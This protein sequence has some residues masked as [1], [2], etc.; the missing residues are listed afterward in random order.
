MSR[1]GA[2]ER[3]E[4]WSNKLLVSPRSDRVCADFEFGQAAGGQRAAAGILNYSEKKQ[5][6]S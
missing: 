4:R 5:N 2:T 3:P 6:C 1:I